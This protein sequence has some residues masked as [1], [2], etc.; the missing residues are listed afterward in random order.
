MIKKTSTKNK[1]EK[2]LPEKEERPLLVWHGS[3]EVL[4]AIAAYTKSTGYLHISYRQL[5]VYLKY[6]FNL[7]AEVNTIKTKLES[8]YVKDPSLRVQLFLLSI[9]ALR[10]QVVQLF[11][12]V[13]GAVR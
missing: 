12:A 7:N 11:D 8:A 9:R 10:K 4:Y 3:Y 1:P 2:Q 13:L 5:A 6:V